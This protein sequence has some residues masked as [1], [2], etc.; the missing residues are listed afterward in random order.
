M[1]DCRSRPEW[2]AAAALGVAALGSVAAMLSKP[3]SRANLAWTLAS[4][5]RPADRNASWQQ[6]A[7]K[8][9]APLDR[10]KR[11]I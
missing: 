2:L 10:I 5:R 1:R 7:G 6:K 11:G 3:D 8:R 9:V 4:W